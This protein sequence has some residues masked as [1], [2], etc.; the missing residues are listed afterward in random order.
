MNPTKQDCLSIIDSWI[1]KSKSINQLKDF[2]LIQ[3]FIFNDLQHVKTNEAKLK[4]SNYLSNG[5]QENE[6]L[7]KIRKYLCL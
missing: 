5:D 2:M 6:E 7:I 3:D 1:K 4:M